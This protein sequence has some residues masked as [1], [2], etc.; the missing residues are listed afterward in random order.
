MTKELEIMTHVATGEVDCRE[1]VDD[2]IGARHIRQEAIMDG[3]LA[4][5]SVK[6]RHIDVNQIYG[7]HIVPETISTMHM[8]VLNEPKRGYSLT[9]LNSDCFEWV[10][11]SIWAQVKRGLNRL[12]FWK[13]S[14]K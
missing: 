7:S 11:M 8:M 12:K 5:K 6:A 4:R 3:H 14:R 10:D 9:Y 1:F 13:E 2:C